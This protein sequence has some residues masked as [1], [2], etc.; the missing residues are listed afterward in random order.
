MLP[1][2]NTPATQ[3]TAAK[4]N[5]EQTGLKPLDIVI[6]LVSHWPW[7]LLCLLLSWGVAEYFIVTSRRI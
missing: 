7:I 3:S 2:E 5:V 4:Q 6:L 1:Y